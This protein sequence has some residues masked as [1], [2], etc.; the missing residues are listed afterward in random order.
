MASTYISTAIST[1]LSSQLPFNPATNMALGVIGGQLSGVALSKFDYIG[2][3][4]WSFI[5]SNEN[6]VM[7]SAK[8]RGRYNPI[9]EKL[10]TY[11]LEKNSQQLKQV[12][13]APSKGEITIDLRDGLF[14]KP[15]EDTY[16]GMKIYLELSNEKTSTNTTE[17]N[18]KDSEYR[19]TR[20]TILVY[21][22]KATIAQL[23][24]FVHDIAK[25]EKIQ[26]N[27]LTVYRPLIYG[28]EK[29]PQIEWDCVKFKSNKTMANTILS[30]DVEKK[31]FDDVE[32]FMNNEQWY[33]G[34]GIDYKRGYLIHGVPGTGKTSCIKAIANRYHLPIF[35]LDF[36]TIKNNSQLISLTNDIVYQVGDRPYIISIEDFDRHDLICEKHPYNRQSKVTIQCLLNVIDGVVE[37]HGRLLFITCNDK[38][39][40]ESIKALV[41]PG[42]VDSTIEIGPCNGEQASRLVNNY[43]GTD[44][45]MENSDMICPPTK[46]SDEDQNHGLTPAELIKKMQFSMSL[47]KTLEF[48]CKDPL[49]I[50]GSAVVT[51][52][53][54]NVVALSAFEDDTQITTDKPPRKI[55]KKRKKTIVDVKKGAVDRIKRDI[56][57][58]TSAKDQC[59]HRKELYE[60]KV[61]KLEIDLEM[62]DAIY[63]KTKTEWDKK[64]AEKKNRQ[65]NK[66]KCGG[67]RKPT[68]P[69][70]TKKAKTDN[71]ADD[72]YVEPSKK[73][74]INT[75]ENVEI[76]TAE[77]QKI[78]NV[79]NYIKFQK[80]QSPRII[81]TRKTQDILAVPIN[82]VSGDVTLIPSA[83]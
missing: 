72:E 16:Q 75:V 6:I 79:N 25:L 56:A 77:G 80:R 28:G 69:T 30:L 26:A 10:E 43:F 22:H 19:I 5:G 21:S 49:A 40:I 62:R 52:L 68:K 37:T 27:I 33:T 60:Y 1:V 61:R 14:R 8:E 24:D 57:T 34:K 23:K 44:I 67:T 74:K 35:N 51:E 64:E 45:K 4:F 78:D 71:D 82:E 20:K 50:K 66:R 46:N 55:V 12:N 73:L 17:H 39:N 7:I 42:R 29:D 41:R 81:M 53:L 9:Y 58:Y 3:W 38:M 54:P 15:I 36:D 63:N 65:K 18:S 83:G 31:L 32:W 2:D 70:Q 11:I 13:L 47:D 48:I 59:L 76:V